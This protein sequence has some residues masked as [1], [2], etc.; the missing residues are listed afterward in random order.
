MGSITAKS[1]FPTCVSVAVFLQ[2]FLLPFLGGIADYSNL[3]KR[4]MALFCYLAVTAN[5]LLFFVTGN[6]Y[7]LGGL[8]FII[9][10]LGFGASIVLYNGLLGEITTE[11]Q[12]DKVSSRGYAYGYLGG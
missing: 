3:K 12:R 6:R 8:L 10:N 5:C 9:A 1:F 11:D 7:L 2:V 4:M